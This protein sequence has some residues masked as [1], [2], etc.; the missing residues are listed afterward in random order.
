MIPSTNN[1][2]LQKQPDKA[3]SSK[4]EEH[5]KH[6]TSFTLSLALS[7]ISVREALL[8]RFCPSQSRPQRRSRCSIASSSASTSFPGSSFLQHVYKNISSVSTNKQEKI[9]QISIKKYMIE[10]KAEKH[11]NST[12]KNSIL[13]S[14]QNTKRQKST[15]DREH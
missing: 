8:T 6:N 15:S 3:I 14:Y 5:S 4:I 11:R 1:I 10:S 12:K 13:I 7:R 2:D 9:A